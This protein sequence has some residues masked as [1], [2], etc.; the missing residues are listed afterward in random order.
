MFND[1]VVVESA[2]SAFNNAALVAPAFFLLALLMCPLFVVVFWCRDAIMEKIKWTPGNML[3][4]I[5]MWTAILTLVWIV[6]F[7]GNYGVLRD[8]LSVLPGTI[9]TIVFLTSLFIASHLR[10][11][12]LPRMNWK[13]WAFVIMGL[14]IVG[15]SDVHTWWGPVLQI[16]ALVLGIV[17][18]RS[19]KAE[20]RPVAGT[21]L[22]ILM[23]T[24]AILMQPEFFRFGQL[25]NLTLIHL[26]AIIILG[27]AS[28]IAL[29]TQNVKPQE[30][31]RQGVY[32]KLKLMMRVVCLLGIALFLLTEAVPMFIGAMIAVFL[33][34]A[35]SVWHAKNVPHEVTQKML[36]V[37]IFMFGIITVMPVIAS[38]GILY[39]ACTKHIDF[40]QETKRLL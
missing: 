7:G 4:K 3:N 24:I 35:M 8:N 25:G 34:S 22:I 21:I 26:G 39:W 29:A 33:L 11:Q 19:A 5:S 10:N 36:A 9:A 2:V 37:T 1:I 27:A 32:T 30:K 15:L 12:P 16:S 31:I 17:L 38:M 6:L 13:R 40:W 20:M 28:M 23:T 14:A 18:G